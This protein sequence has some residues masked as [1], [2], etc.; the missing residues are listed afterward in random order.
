MDQW[1]Q[2]ALRT[3][4]MLAEYDVYLLKK[5]YSRTPSKITSCCAKEPRRCP[6]LGGEVLTRRNRS[7]LWLQRGAFD[8]VQPDVTKVGGI[9]EERRIDG[10]GE[11]ALY[12]P[13]LEHWHGSG[14]RSAPSA[15][16]ATNLV[17]YITGSPY[18]DELTVGG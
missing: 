12:P 15:F 2:M 10:P 6:L 8:I 14:R 11:H 4:H 3:A 16:P 7:N 13:R 1:L 9:S 5:R 17:E 18:I